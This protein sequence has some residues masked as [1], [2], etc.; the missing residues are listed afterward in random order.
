MSSARHTAD[1]V[2]IPV[3]CPACGQGMDVHVGLTMTASPVSHVECVRCHL[4]VLAL[5]PG[6][7]LAGPKPVGQER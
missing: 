3:T 5:L 2:V 6:P 7:V 1:Y 4:Q